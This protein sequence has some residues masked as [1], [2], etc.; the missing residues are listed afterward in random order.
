MEI[1]S[2]PHRKL[3]QTEQNWIKVFLLRTKFPTNKSDER[4]AAGFF[5]SHL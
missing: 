2:S 4:I 3:R 5:S 1:N